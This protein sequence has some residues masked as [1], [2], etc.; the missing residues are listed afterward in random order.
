MTAAAASASA[1]G[2]VLQRRAIQCSFSSVFHLRNSGMGRKE[3]EKVEKIFMTAVALPLGLMG[4][5]GAAAWG[6]R[7]IFP[8]K[9]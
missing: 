2:K 8:A 5:A 6:Y 4:F 1:A 3:S 9:K 7:N